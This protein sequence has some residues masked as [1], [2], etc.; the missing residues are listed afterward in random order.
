MKDHDPHHL[1]TQYPWQWSSVTETSSVIFKM[2]GASAK[3]WQWNSSTEDHVGEKHFG[4]L[5][6]LANNKETL[7][8]KHVGKCASTHHY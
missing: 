5:T 4:N 8:A 7:L 2:Y 1:P 3:Y 6:S